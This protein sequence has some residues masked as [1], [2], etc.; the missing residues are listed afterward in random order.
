[1]DNAEAERR[2]AEQKFRNFNLDN[3]RI[4]CLDTS[5]L[6]AII[7]YVKPLFQILPQIKWHKNLQRCENWFILLDY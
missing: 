6:H 4:R 7:P 1:M 5:T 2:V 3:E